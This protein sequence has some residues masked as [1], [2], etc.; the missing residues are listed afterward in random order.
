[1]STNPTWISILPLL[2]LHHHGDHANRGR[3]GGA[4]P[5][6][7]TNRAYSWSCR[8]RASRLLWLATSQHRQDHHRRKP[9]AA[10]R[11]RR[12]RTPRHSA[13]RHGGKTNLKPHLVYTG[14][15]SASPASAPTS[16]SRRGRMGIGPESRKRQRLSTELSRGATYSR[17]TNDY[18]LPTELYF[19]D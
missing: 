8:R 5:G 13:R 1:M 4:P 10:A 2:L 17:K 9:P 7:R 11:T 16:R 3:N 19:L 15:P 18:I 6:Q 14:Y 12:Q